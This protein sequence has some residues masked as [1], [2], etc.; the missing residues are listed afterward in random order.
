MKKLI[1]IA[2][3]GFIVSSCF[4][5]DQKNTNENSQYLSRSTVGING[6]SKTL[7]TNT[8]TYYIQQSIGQASVIGT[9]SKNNYTIRQGF[10]QPIQSVKGKS[11]IINEKFFQA[12]LYPNPFYQYIN[13]SFK[14]YINNN[15]FVVIYSISGSSVFSDKYSAIQQLNI[16]LSYLPEGVYVIK[17]TS[18]NTQLVKKIFKR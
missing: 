3:T 7:I 15:V 16:P 1:F 6:L 8:G 12:N 4:A 17:I 9:Y 11:N 18:N 10:L 14:E 5:Q 2:L 13:I